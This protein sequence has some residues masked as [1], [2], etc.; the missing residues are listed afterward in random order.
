MLVRRGRFITYRQLA[1][2]EEL[3]GWLVCW[4]WR[5]QDLVPWWKG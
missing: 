2:L 1:R 3:V 5:V 4:L